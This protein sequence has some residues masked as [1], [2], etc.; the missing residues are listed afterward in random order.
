MP[1]DAEMLLPLALRVFGNSGTALPL[2]DSAVYAD[3][4]IASDLSRLTVPFRV[5]Y[6]GRLTASSKHPGSECATLDVTQV[7]RNHSL[8]RL[9]RR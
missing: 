6:E 3:A 2:T 8:D 1:V 5:Q 7:G 9:I 4:A